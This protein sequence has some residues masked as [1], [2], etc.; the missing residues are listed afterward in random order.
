MAVSLG[1][2]V[3]QAGS[4]SALGAEGPRFESG[5]PDQIP[6]ARSPGVGSRGVQQRSW[7]DAMTK[8][9]RIYKPART[10][11]QQ[12]RAK[13]QEWVLE[14]EP[15]LRRRHDPLMGWTSSGDPRQQI[16]LYFDTR[17]AAVPH[18]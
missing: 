9:A 15:E 8:K 4:A 13:T 18:P 16:R 1:R 7:I 2:G 14:Y 12:G 10:A 3:A 5:L 11:M 6:P 17:D